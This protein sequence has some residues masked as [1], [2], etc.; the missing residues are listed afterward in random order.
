MEG[1]VMPWGYWIAGSIALIAARPVAKAA[2]RLAAPKVRGAYG[3]FKVRR[4]LRSFRSKNFARANDI[5]IPHSHNHGTSQLDHVLVSRY[6]IF[7]IETKNYSGKVKGKKEDKEWTQIYGKNR[8]RKFLNPILQNE[9]H[10]RSLRKVLHDYPD[11]PYHNLVVFSD[12][13]KSPWIPHVIHMSNLKHVIKE[14]CKGEPV[15]SAAEVRQIKQCIDA[16]TIKDKDA[17]KLH[18]AYA[19]LAA[20]MNAQKKQT[21]P[22][23]EHNVVLPEQ[24]SQEM[25]NR[26]EIAN[27]K[28]LLTDTGAMLN[29]NG[30]TASIHDHFEAAKRNEKGK[31][32]Q[33]GAGFDHFIC[34]YTNTKFPASE[35]D[36]FYRGMWIAYLKKNP[37][38]VAFM[39]E[40]DPANLGNSFKCTRVLIGYMHDSDTFISQTRNSEWY[41]N[42]ASRKSRKNQSLD[43]FISTAE[44]KSTHP[45]PVS[46]SHHKE[47]A[48]KHDR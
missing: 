30:K 11:V 23:K 28:M 26:A 37:D 9:S 24:T 10:I 13:C 36:S 29:I 40:C 16:A 4:I 33:P 17:R 47:N 44:Q 35:A 38:L 8:T 5:L 1:N 42:M 41:R 3:E 20:E 2:W 15:L 22:S 39:R 21:K 7:V 25:Q 18:K 32:V 31:S 19:Q 34:P 6:G 45:D 48:P 43:D 14:N 46:S 12:N 27:R